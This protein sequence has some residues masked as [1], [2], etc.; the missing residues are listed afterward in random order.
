MRDF[1]VRCAAKATAHKTGRICEK[2]GCKGELKDS[3]INFGDNLE[4]HILE[5]STDNCDMADLVLCM[6]SSMRV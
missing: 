3:I 6:G 1:R 4:S 5:K 2:P